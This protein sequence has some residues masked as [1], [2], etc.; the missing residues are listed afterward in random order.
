MQLSIRQAMRVLLGSA[1]LAATV[2]GIAPAVALAEPIGF[3]IPAQDAAAAL[4]EFARQSK[5]QILFAFERVSGLQ[6]NELTGQHEPA[7]A[8]QVL[9]RGTGLTVQVGDGGI[10]VVDVAQAG[11]G[12]VSGDDNSGAMPIAHAAPLRMSQAGEAREEAASPSQDI[13]PAADET[14]QEIVVTG[15]R[16][17]TVATKLNVEVRDLPQAITL[18]PRAVIDELLITRI[19]DVSYTTVGVQPVSPYTGG[20]SLGFFIRGFRGS[21]ILVDGY[22][23]G[24]ISGSSS[25][26]IDFSTVDRVE[27]LRGPASVLYGQG[28]PGGI[29]NVTTKRPLDRFGL[30]AE[31]NVGDGRD[32]TLRGTFDVTGPLVSDRLLVRLNAAVEDSDSFRDFVTNKRR[33]VAPSLELR[34]TDDITVNLDYV[35]DRFSYTIDRFAGTTRELIENLPVTRNLSEPWLPNTEME[36]QKFR[37]Q[38]EWRFAPDWALRASGFTYKHE[39]DNAPEIG[40]LGL[41]SPG[42]TTVNR[43]YTNYPGADRNQRRDET[44]SAQL[45]GHFASGPLLHDLLVSY[46][47]V[48]AFFNYYA[49]DGDIG[50]IDYRNPVYSAGPLLPAEDFSFQGASSSD[51]QAVYGQDLI[52]LGEH[53]KLL[54]GM[55]RDSITTRSYLDAD[56]TLAGRTQHDRKTTPRAGLI[57]RPVSA[58]TLYLS[59]GKSFLPNA[60]RGDRFGNQFEPEVGEAFEAGV[61]QEIL[62]GRMALTAAAFEITK[63]NVLTID[64]SDIRFSVNSGEARSRGFELE[65]DGTLRPGWRLRAGVAYVDAEVTKSLNVANGRVGDGLA[66]VSPWTANLNTSYELSGAL[67]AVSIGGNASYASSRPARV[68]NPNWSL[69]SHLKLDAFVAYDFGAARAQLNFENILDERILL[70]NGLGLVSFDNSRRVLLTLRYRFAGLE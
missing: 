54:V 26:V 15:L 32:G 29:V 10:L 31:L 12:R 2:A 23:A 61:K 55:R 5:R 35:H 21:A 22:N 7:E 40:I 27:V 14:L 24:V 64:P 45:S 63:S 8:I 62:D 47:S 59:W 57:W 13:K 11:A 20:V 51:Y 1:G 68:P 69:D 17:R 43:Y 70:A 46:D 19:E 9:L 50:P 41:T 18:I 39:A 16:Q 33:L 37:A 58:T 49:M 25:S 34:A 6:S 48:D 28:N 66:G 56:R 30:G 42:A 3:D 44:L 65:M 4:T 52:S 60:G 38:V 67:S 36:I 53:W